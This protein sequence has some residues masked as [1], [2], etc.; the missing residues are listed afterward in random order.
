MPVWSD[1]QVRMHYFCKLY[2]PPCLVEQIVQ[3]DNISTGDMAQLTVVDGYN[4]KEIGIK[5]VT[6]Q[7]WYS[8]FSTIALTAE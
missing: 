8:V 2:R 1:I 3:P 6:L 7:V 5:C 4:G